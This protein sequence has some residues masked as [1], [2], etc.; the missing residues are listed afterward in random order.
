[1][2]VLYAADGVCI[3]LASII[4]YII[5]TDMII[6]SGVICVNVSVIR[7]VIEHLSATTAVFG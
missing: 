4:P 2:L 7:I 6:V 1:M 3:T 5:G